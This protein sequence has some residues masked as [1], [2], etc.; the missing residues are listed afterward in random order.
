MIRNLPPGLHARRLLSELDENGF[1][2][3]NIFVYMPT[4]LSTSQ[5]KG[6]AFVNFVAE[7]HASRLMNAWN[8]THRFGV[9]MD[10]MPLNLVPSRN[11]P[12]HYL[13]QSK[14]RRIKSHAFR[15]F[16]ASEWGGM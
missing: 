3:T 4:V 16:V 15:P 2:D 7:E 14:L 12:S 13:V 11:Q 5:S 6:F 1:H 8:G 9:R 10:Q